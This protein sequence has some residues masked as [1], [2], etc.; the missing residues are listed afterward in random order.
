MFDFFKYLC[1]CLYV[2]SSLFLCI[3]GLHRYYLVYL[4]KRGMRQE[5][6]P[7]QQPCAG[8]PR[9]TVQLPVYNEMY[10]TERL[11][12]A[13]CR[14]DYPRDL[15]EIQ[16]LD[17]ST[18]DTSSIAKQCASE[19]RSLGFDIK[20][21]ARES[22]EGYKAGALAAGLAE[23]RGEL[24]A[25]FDADFVPPANF[26]KKTVPAFSDS[27]VGIVQTRWGHLNRDY[28]L[29]TK[30]QSVLLDGHFMIEQTARCLNGLFLNF[31]GTAGIIR[32]KCIEL[33]GGWQHDTLTE[34]LD[35]SYRAQI[36]G[37]KA[38]YLPEVISEAELPVDMNAFK[39]QQHR[40]VKGGVQ[41]AG[42]LLPSVLGGEEIPFRVKV[43]SLFHLLG[44][45]SYL[46]LLMTILL[47]VPMNF[48][49]DD[50]WS[51][52]LFIASIIAVAIGTFA[53]IRFYILAVRETHGESAKRFYKYI[54]LALGLG[55]GIAVN[56]AKA[57]L[58]A[59]LGKSS[60]FVRTPK[61][62]VVS[63]E[64]RWRA[65]NYVSSR[66]MTTFFELV[67]CLFFTFQV[68]YAFYMGFFVWVPF[69]LLMQFGFG[70]TAF[71]SMYRGS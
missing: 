18:D 26:L 25:I 19:L 54:P 43:E 55:A 64:D 32:K 16:I 11:I 46:F 12:R 34:D 4:Y 24:V 5:D 40:W 47:V 10:V 39:I 70:Y 31:N 69:L 42:K 38:V 14:I 23:A 8:L 52:D 48:F 45:F 59:V 65:L 51:N 61:Y 2:F 60:G 71:S 22:R 36:D 20:R 30:A 68:G 3:F 58:E 35:L 49:W 28:S 44:N 57:V 33:S 13:V 67:L 15:L 9:V 7:K 41:T 50:I 62:A 17:D 6:L 56:N 37:W 1:M 66:G 21:V 63:K 53:I 27:Q 29:L